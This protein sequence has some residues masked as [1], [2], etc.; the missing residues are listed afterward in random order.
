M[1]MIVIEEKAITSYGRKNAQAREALKVWF[2]QVQ[3][4]T[5]SSHNDLLANFVTA[6]YI[7]QGRYVFDI[8]GNHY[9]L[10]VGGPGV[11]F[12]AHR[13]ASLN[14]TTGWPFPAMAT[15]PSA[16]II[17]SYEPGLQHRSGPGQRV[18][19]TRARRAVVPRRAATPY[20]LPIRWGLC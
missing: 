15:A 19:A 3:L 7:G 5:G 17:S 20:P 16:R 10:P 6:D 18:W 1:A 2:A 13:R 8:K 11:V 12:A 9:P 4:C 14:S